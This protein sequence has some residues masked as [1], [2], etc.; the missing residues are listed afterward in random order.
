MENLYI[1]N[2]AVD[3]GTVDYGDALNLQRDLVPLVR[4]GVI[5]DVLLILEH[6][7]VYTVGRGKKPENYIGIDV[8]ETERGGDVT[9]H[10]PG[11]VV[12]YPILNLERNGI[13][14]ARNLVNMLEGVFVA[15][16]S[17]LGYEATPS[18]EPGIWVSG[19]KVG[20]IGL[21]IREGVSFHGVAINISEE[22]LPWFSRINPCGLHPGNMGFVPADKDELKRAVLFSFQEG[23]HEFRM[24][25]RTSF[26]HILRGNIH[27]PS[28]DSGT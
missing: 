6:P 25:D 7:P 4:K 14:G 10:G 13:R 27:Y 23:L 15:A 2:P 18:N 8:I 11:Q 20:S 24:I 16:L 22:V 1:S 21:A 9:Y 12:F 17:S 26:S 19:K 3:L 5:G 28:P